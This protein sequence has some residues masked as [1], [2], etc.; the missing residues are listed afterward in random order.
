MRGA[1]RFKL[2]IINSNETSIHAPSRGATMYDLR[3]N[4]KGLTSI[5]APHAGCDVFPIHLT[6]VQMTL[7]F[8][9]PMRG[10]TGHSLH[11]FVSGQHFNPRTP[12]GCDPNDIS[13]KAL[14]NYFN[15][16]TPGG[17]QRDIPHL[18]FDI[19][20]TSIHAPHAGAT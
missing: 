19:Q 6:L 18:S 20:C 3:K 1:T 10:A 5:H 7:Q 9:H 16:R 17:G 15:S 14:Q 12:C 2:N 8:T 13:L 4:K 11:L